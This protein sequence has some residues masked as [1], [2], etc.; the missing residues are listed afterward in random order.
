MG[1]QKQYQNLHSS[2]PQPKNEL[3]CQM[4]MANHEQNYTC[5]PRTHPHIKP[6]YHFA[7]KYVTDI[8]NVLPSKNLLDHNGNP[9]TPYFLA[10]CHKPKIGNYCIF[11]CPTSFKRYTAQTDHTQTQQATRGIFIGF[12]SNQAGWLFYTENAI[13]THHIH[14]SHDAT[15]DEFFDSTLV[16]NKHPFQGSLATRH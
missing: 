11:G 14:E 4:T 2:T 13:G 1:K 8:I 12:P 15:F 16:F 10:F 9:T 5:H 3:H 7:A 6:L